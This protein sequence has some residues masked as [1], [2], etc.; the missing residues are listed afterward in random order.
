VLAADTT[1]TLT[2]YPAGTVLPTPAPNPTETPSPVPS[3]TP[4]PTA[5]PVP[6][7]TPLVTP[8]PPPVNPTPTPTLPP[9]T[10][11]F[12]NL[13]VTIAISPSTCIATGMAGETLGYSA[14]VSAPAP[15]GTSYIYAWSSP[16]TQPAFEVVVPPPTINLQYGI[17]GGNEAQVIVPA[18]G[19]FGET[20]ES[21]AMAVTLYLEGTAVPYYGTNVVLGSDGN[22]VRTGAPIAA[23]SLTCAAIGDS[24]HR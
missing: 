23:G 13:A 19:Q 4:I 12:V 17:G 10:P 3:V 16:E 7:A 5:T 21:G 1:G 22:I 18:F 9:N 2:L 24:R 6:T 15:A 20:G 14:T 8:S 11:G